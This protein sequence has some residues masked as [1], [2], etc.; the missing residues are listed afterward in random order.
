MSWRRINGLIRKIHFYLHIKLLVV[1]TKLQNLWNGF[2][3]FF[4][5]KFGMCFEGF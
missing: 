4:E 5:V 1:A 3:N 2:W